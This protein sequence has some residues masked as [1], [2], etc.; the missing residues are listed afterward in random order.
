[1]FA[2]SRAIL[3]AELARYSNNKSADD[4]AWLTHIY[5]FASN[6]RR[7]GLEPDEPDFDRLTYFC[8]HCSDHETVIA[9]IRPR[10]R[11]P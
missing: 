1:M 10:K 2:I 5:K 3:S 4:H 6:L 11:R 7:P 9:P 8:A